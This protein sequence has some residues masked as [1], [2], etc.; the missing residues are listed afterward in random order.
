MRLERSRP[1]GI[2]LPHVESIDYREHAD[3]CRRMARLS[4]LPHIKKELLNMAD[5][6]DQLAG[7][8]QQ[9]IAQGTRHQRLG[10]APAG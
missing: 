3:E 8:R 1:E 9:E 5:T 4:A 2:Y 7:Q 6:W 10:G